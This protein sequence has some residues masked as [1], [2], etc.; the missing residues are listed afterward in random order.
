MDFL[1]LGETVMFKQNPP[2]PEYVIC[3]RAHPNKIFNN[4][5]LNDFKI[6]LQGWANPLKK[7]RY[8]EEL[9]ALPPEILAKAHWAHGPFCG[10]SAGSAEPLQ[11]SITLKRY[12][13]FQQVAMDYGIKKYVFHFNYNAELDRPDK[14]R[15]RFTSFWREYLS[16]QE[17]DMLFLH[18]NSFECD[19]DYIASIMSKIDD[20]RMGLCIDLGHLHC[21]GCNIEEWLHTL[22]PWIHYFHIHDNQ[23]MTKEKFYDRDKHLPPGNGTFPWNKFKNI[24]QKN[25]S[26]I[27]LAIE[28]A[29]GGIAQ[30]I[31][32]LNIIIEDKEAS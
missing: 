9:N 28:C 19:Q 29:V 16:E 11:R 27:P 8:N 32:Q 18:E 23:G 31:K 21:M 14:W 3:D 12:K 2:K 20:E 4:Q 25:F 26:N 22:K 6:E 17:S 30:A 15:T 1:K 5:N 13:E 10:L 7:D 24:Y